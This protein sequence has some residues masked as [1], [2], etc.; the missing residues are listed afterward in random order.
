[1]KQFF[2][3]KIVFLRMTF[4]ANHT[5]LSIGR[6]KGTWKEPLSEDCEHIQASPSTLLGEELGEETKNCTAGSGVK[7]PA[8]WL[9]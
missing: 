9:G 6:G 3:N 1:M 5:V 4:L 7:Y 2:W 8:K